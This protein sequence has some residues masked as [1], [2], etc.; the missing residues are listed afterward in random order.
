MDRKALIILLVSFVVLM[1]WYPLTNYLYPPVPV[2]TN[3][4]DVSTNVPGTNLGPAETIQAIAGTNVLSGTNAVAVQ[5]APAEEQTLVVTNNEAIYTFTSHGGGIK[6]IELKGYLAEVCEKDDTN[7]LASLNTKAP[8]PAFAILEGDKLELPASFH[9]SRTG[10]VVRAETELPSGLVLIKEF[11]LSTNYLVAARVRY[12]NRTEGAIRLPE[13]ELV[14]GTATPMGGR[15]E[16]QHIGLEWHNGEDTEKVTDPWFENKTLGC[17]PGTPR[18]LYMAGESNVVWAAVHNQFFTMIAVPE[19]KVEQVV[20]RR[21]QLPQPTQE[22]IEENPSLYAHPMG[23][24]TALVLGAQSLPP[25]TFV[26]Q[27]YL[28]YAGP[29]EYQTLTRLPNNMDHVMGFEGFFGF[30]AK[31]LLLSM[32]AFHGLGL[33][34]GL[35]II[36]ITVIIKLLF[37]PL[38]N[39]S[40]KSMKRM[41]A[42]QPQMKALQEKYK[43]DPKKMNMKLMEFMKEHKV[44]PLGSCLP[45]LLQIPVFFGFYK[46]LQSAIELR[47]AEFLWVCDLSQPDT[48]FYIGGFPFNLFPFIMGATMLWQARMT[49]AAPGMDPMQQQMM[50][51]MPLMIV[52]F[53]YNFSA[54]LTLYWTVQNLLSIAQMKITRTAEEKSGPGKNAPAKPAQLPPKKKK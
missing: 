14:I 18:P 15:D 38:T 10:E 21:V 44:S 6:L 28:L 40:T 7:R 11:E 41:S 51:Y 45:L 5:K 36:A 22:E 2:N 32:N 52:F 9:L 48:L 1:G 43:D 37:W 19:V 49:P 35:C 16:R 29:K 27:K 34:Y 3:R 13:R 53:L 50:R 26:E 46:M 33:G 25:K 42:L 23:Y 39:A 17:F 47:G 31:A 20:G 24:Q 8:Q 4:V 30:F 54:G 12:E